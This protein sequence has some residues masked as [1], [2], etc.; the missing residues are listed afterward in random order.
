MSDSTLEIACLMLVYHASLL[1]ETRAVD[2]VRASPLPLF[3]TGKSS[4]LFKHPSGIRSSWRPVDCRPVL[5]FPIHAT[6]YETNPSILWERGSSQQHLIGS[7]IDTLVID[8]IRCLVCVHA[9]PVQKGDS[10]FE[11][12]SFHGVGW[13][14]FITFQLL[15]LFITPKPLWLPLFIYAHY[16]LCTHS[17]SSF[18]LIACMPW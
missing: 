18:S 7:G 14:S 12:R 4:L 8:R 15:A 1:A 3:H 6:T 11:I 10:M 9:R 16:V 5:R 17:Q 2:F 13:T